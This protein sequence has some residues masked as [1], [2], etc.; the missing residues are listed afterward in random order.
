MTTQAQAAHRPPSSAGLAPLLEVSGLTA[1]Y[2]RLTVLQ[3]VSLRVHPGEIVSLIGPNGAGKSTLLLS[4]SGMTR[5]SAGAVR[6][7]GFQ[8]SGRTAH[9]IARL[10]IS[11][12]PEDRSLFGSLTVDEHL[13]LTAKAGALDVYRL[14]PELARMKNKRAGVMSG[15][16]QQMLALARALVTNPRVLLVD[17]MSLG[18]APVVVER[19][20][21]A[22]V[23]I[24]SKNG[25]GILLVE[26]HVNL[27][28][29]Y[30]DRAY[31]LSGGRIRAE[32]GAKDFLN[33]W[34]EI[35]AS[36]LGKE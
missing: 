25:I 27:A 29:R 8:V 28:L 15:G 23:D 11:H 7:D 3:D 30:A 31:V 13:R 36:Y 4:I 19:L 33:R 22:L 35:E 5:I 20:F 10:G 26:Q 21:A 12:V 16:E 6:L 32:G 24:A 34:H 17:E 9:G 2:G 14:F 18:L 1:G